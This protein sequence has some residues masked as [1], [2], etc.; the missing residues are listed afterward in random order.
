MEFEKWYTLSKEESY[1]V[2]LDMCSCTH[3]LKEKISIMDDL[4]KQLSMADQ[5]LDELTQE[6]ES[7]ADEIEILKDK[8]HASNKEIEDLHQELFEINDKMDSK[9]PLGWLS[10]LPFRFT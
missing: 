10:S 7:S 2:Y 5:Q 6:V 4:E 1:Q 8:L 9:G 3:Q